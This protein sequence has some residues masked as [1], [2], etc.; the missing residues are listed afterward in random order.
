MVNEALEKLEGLFVGMYEDAS[1][2]GRPT[3]VSP[4]GPPRHSDPGW[5][6]RGFTH[7]DARC[8]VFTPVDPPPII[9]LR[10]AS[11]N[12]LGYA[13]AWKRNMSASPPVPILMVKK[14]AADFNALA[15]QRST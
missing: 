14:V 10:L 13:T 8:Y 4:R 15:G 9:A 6:V 7:S 1:K 5:L 12:P 11:A 3:C 2:G